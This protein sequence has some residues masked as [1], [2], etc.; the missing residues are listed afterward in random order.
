M[1]KRNYYC[2]V[3][4]L[5]DLIPDDKKLH[6]SSVELRDYLREELHASDFELVKLF[7][8]P[9]DHENLINLLFGGEFEWDERGNYTRES[10]EQLVDKKQFELID[11][12]AFPS[13]FSDF[14]EFYHDD[15]EEFPKVATVKFLTERWYKTLAGSGNEFVAAFAEYKQ[16]M[17]NIMLALNGRKHSIPFEDAIIGD[18]EVS[19]ALKK[20]RS[21]DFG[22][23]NE[24][25]DI[26]S[27]V[28]I[29]EIENILDR[30]LKLDNHL[31]HILDEITFFNYF[32]IE[33]VLAFVQKLFIVERWFELDKEKG[34]QIF[35]QLLEE[36]QSNFEF[37]E[38]FA[39]TY[40]KRK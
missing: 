5:P 27:I 30:E 38:E 28:Q 11:T 3:A 36:L 12:S 23:S 26:E 16:N 18:D 14:I 33:K 20:S 17:A 2:L 13:Y 1:N 8:L 24:I 21:R 40:G 6:F 22:L 34:Q 25:N 39:I 29:F 37:P 32:T 35:N 10:L 19:H 9:W 15:E 4:G 31:W 7:Y